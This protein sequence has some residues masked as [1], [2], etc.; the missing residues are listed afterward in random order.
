MQR[1]KMLHVINATPSAQTPTYEAIG[2]DLEDFSVEMN[3][4][5]DKKKNI[6]GK[7]KNTLS[8]Y[9]PQAD[10]DTY[11]AIP[12]SKT[13]EFLQDILD[14]RKTDDDVKTDVVEVHLWEESGNS[15]VEFK[16][17][18]DEVIVEIVSY[19]GDTVAYGIPY[20]LHYSNVRTVGTYNA[21][22]KAFTPTVAVASGD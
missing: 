17:Y 12:G 6:L 3:A 4:Q 8:G 7:N 2:E 21:T 18:K 1:E 10:V 15:G 14:N 20:N 16:A 22:T 9:E 11:Y 5:V 13:F 19:G